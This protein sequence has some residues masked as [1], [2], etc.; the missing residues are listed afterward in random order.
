MMRGVL[1]SRRI[2]V[3]IPHI[4]QCISDVIRTNTA[5]R[6]GLLQLLSDVP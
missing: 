2:N 5:M 1:D 3:S 6:A 4:Q